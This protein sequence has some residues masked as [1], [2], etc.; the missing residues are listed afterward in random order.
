[1]KFELA[2]CSDIPE[3]VNFHLKNFDGYY[4]TSLGKEVLENYY[5]FFLSNDSNIF[6]IVKDQ[7][8][9]IGLA[10]FVPFFDEQ[11]SNFYKKH[12]LILS[13]NIMLKLITFNK[14]VLKGTLSR[15]KSVF[16]SYDMENKLP[17]ISLLSLAIDINYRSQGIGEELIYFSENYLRK[18]GY[19]RYYLS[20]LEKNIRGISFYKKMGFTQVSSKR[21]LIYFEK[22]VLE[23]KSND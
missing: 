4:L 3:I 16:N 1:M 20:V 10:L 15:V 11:I 6:V 18:Y 19:E 12:F 8:E 9:I 22:S 17:E 7:G 23:G 21:D 14:E 13:K 5:S 2:Q